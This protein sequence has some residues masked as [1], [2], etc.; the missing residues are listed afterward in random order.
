MNELA[1]IVSGVDGLA[2]L[3]VA[4]FFPLWLFVSPLADL[5]T[6]SYWLLASKVLLIGAGFSLQ[7]L[8]EPI[9][10]LSVFI[11]VAT[12]SFIRAFRWLKDPV[13][14]PTKPHMAPP[15]K[16]SDQI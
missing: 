6:N 15:M 7:E 12:V 14:K 16:P 9:W 3:F 11:G 10:F 4:V 5:I 8:V 1:T 13:K 2:F